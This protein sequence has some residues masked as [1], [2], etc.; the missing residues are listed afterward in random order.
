AVRAGAIG[1][2]TPSVVRLTVVALGVWLA[3]LA[4][5]AVSQVQVWRDTDTLWR[6]AIEVNPACSWCHV[7][8]GVFLL[9]A[10][11]GGGPAIEHLERALAL[12][13]DRVGYHRHMGLALVKVGRP[14]MAVAHF[15]AVLD[16][17]PDEARINVEVRNDLG[18]TFMELGQLD[19]AIGQFQ[20]VIRLAPAHV[21]ALTN[22]GIGLGALD[23][24]RE[25]LRYLRR[26]VELSP[27]APV[28]RFW[29]ACASLAVGDSAGAGAQARVLRQL[30][31]RLAERLEAG[32]VAKCFDE[33]RRSGGDASLRG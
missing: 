3:G 19:E 15:R 10:R 18:V 30:D 11:D 32:L 1:A 31:P 21:G 8:L 27:E 22:L 16:R 14:Q 25:G 9:G 26:A 24:P 23:R 2:L 13:P 33:F 28:P 17:Y 4:A 20:E 5:L 12:R 7:Q 6:Y 29:L